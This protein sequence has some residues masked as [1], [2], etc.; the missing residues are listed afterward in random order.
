M[1]K[2]VYMKQSV[3]QF[4]Y[5]LF[6]KPCKLD[7]MVLIDG[8]ILNPIPINRVKRKKDDLLIAVDVNS[9]ISF[10]KHDPEKNSSLEEENGLNYFTFIMKKGFQFLPK[11]IDE[12]LNYFSLLSQS[13]NLMV[14]QISA[15]TIEM[16]Q[17]DIL[18]KIPMNSYEPFL[19][20]KSEEIIKAGELAMHKALFD[21]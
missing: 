12:E 20:Y 4:L 1:K 9:P 5:L 7:E 10:G 2:A 15:M 6:F 11:A 16:Y 13:G 17:P 3:L 8:G 14:Q 19:F 21:F 18:I